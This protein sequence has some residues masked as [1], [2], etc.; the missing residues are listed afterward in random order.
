MHPME[1]SRVMRRRIRSDPTRWLPIAGTLAIMVAVAV[2][3]VP[4]LLH[5]RVD[6]A[7]I[8][9]GIIWG[10][11]SEI[12]RDEARFPFWSAHVLWGRGPWLYLAFVKALLRD[13]RLIVL[14]QAIAW[15]AACAWCAAMLSR[16][17]RRPAAKV[18]AWLLLAGLAASAPLLLWT[19]A[20]STES[21]SLSLTVAA[22]AAAVRLTFR[23]TRA[24]LVA[25]VVILALLASVRDTNTIVVLLVGIGAL[26]GALV[27]LMRRAARPAR[28]ALAIV[29][30]VAIGAGVVNSVLASASGRWS[31]PLLETATLRLQADATAGPYLRARDFP[32]DAAVAALA[33]PLVYFRETRAISD[34]PRYA[35]L[36]D[37]VRRD[38]RAVYGRFLVTH[39]VWALRLAYE[40]RG[41]LLVPD[42]DG[43]ARGSNVTIPGVATAAEYGV[44]LRSGVVLG[45]VAVAAA[46]L[47]VAATLRAPRRTGGRSRGRRWIVI[48]GATVGLWLVHALA[49]FHGDSLEI[50]RHAITSALTLRLAIVAAIVGAIDGWPVAS[51]SREELPHL[52]GVGDED[53]DLEPDGSGE[54]DG[55]APLGVGEAER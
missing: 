44:F 36:R 50:P 33:D 40:D 24:A 3:A 25:F 18:V 39:P 55:R 9:D 21:L 19:G 7:G 35:P 1:R 11:D 16:A 12:Y 53:D 41:D 2:Y 13:I 47:L 54:H 31:M 34:S 32:R 10:T 42:V 26:L 30:A 27:A 17:V 37:W 45:L 49:A 43:Y 28:P 23:P 29:A 52:R 5:G 20:P 15:A 51:R 38:G 6:R 14:V 46:G 48:V 22:F 4:V 8:P